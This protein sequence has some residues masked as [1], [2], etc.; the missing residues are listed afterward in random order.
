MLYQEDNEKYKKKKIR[1]T[2]EKLLYCK[3]IANLVELIMLH[4]LNMQSFYY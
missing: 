4:L 1:L 3:I 2:I